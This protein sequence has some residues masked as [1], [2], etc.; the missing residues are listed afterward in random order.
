[1]VTTLWCAAAAAAT[2]LPRSRAGSSLFPAR[3]A[4]R[5]GGAAAHARGSSRRSFAAT[6][7]FGL[8]V[9]LPLKG[10]QGLADFFT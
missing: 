6:A 1:M 3:T 8:A 7:V 10:G 4:R 9:V 5:R 2:P